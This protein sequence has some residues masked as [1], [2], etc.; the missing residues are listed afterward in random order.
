MPVLSIGLTPIFPTIEVVPVV[1]IP[2]F[3]R[4][5]KLPAV[6]RLTGACAALAAPAANPKISSVN[7]TEFIFFKI[8]ASRQAL[9]RSGNFWPRNTVRSMVSSPSD[10]LPAEP[11]YALESSGDTCASTHS[12]DIAEISLSVPARPRYAVA[13]FI[14]STAAPTDPSA[15][16]C[17]TSRGAIDHVHGRRTTAP[18]SGSADLAAERT[19]APVIEQYGKK[20]APRERAERADRLSPTAARRSP[21]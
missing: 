18:Q 21:S 17:V 10:D 3:D 9:G 4:I 12:G 16:G 1:E 7:S 6:P 14:A 13:T 5:T 15:R 19:T 20:R 2:D 8:L 11:Q